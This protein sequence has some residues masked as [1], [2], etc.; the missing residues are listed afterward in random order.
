[1]TRRVIWSL[2]SLLVAATLGGLWFLDN[3]EPVPATRRDRP[4]RQARRDSY[5]ALERFLARMARPLTRTADPQSLDRL[6]A[7]GVVILDPNRRYHLTPARRDALLG[8]VAAGGYLVLVPESDSAGDEMLDALDLEWADPWSDRWPGHAGP[9]E[10]EL[11]DLPSMPKHVTVRIPGASRGLVADGGLGLRTGDRA[12]DWR[13]GDP[14]YGDLFVHHTYGRGNITTVVGFDGMASNSRLG[15][16]DHAEILWSLLERY[17]PDGPVTLIS[18]LH[19]PTLG[20]WLVEHASAGLLSFGLL[21]ALWL[22]H[23][24]PRAGRLVPERPAARRELGEHLAAM[25]R[26]IWRAGALSSLLETAR[27]AFQARL[28]SRHPAIAALAGA[29]RVAALADLTDLPESTVRRA[30]EANGDTPQR[31]TAIL[32]DLQRLERSL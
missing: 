30:L 1:L 12:P 8:W 27:R 24:I 7:G 26:F 2:T 16:E 14:T 5:L 28:L 19:V 17:Q 9:D 18:R 3:F 6:P 21:I 13:A 4:S 15:A 11:E 10:V 29:G 20:E 25:G 31:F 23:I 22:W 32:A